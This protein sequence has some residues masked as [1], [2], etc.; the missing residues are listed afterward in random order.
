MAVIKM[1]SKVISY[2]QLHFLNLLERA[3]WFLLTTF[4]V[5]EMYYLSIIFLFI[6]TYMY[7][8]TY[9]KN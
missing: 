1:A 8:I 7:F 4:F 5:I 2:G 6:P 9:N 3:R